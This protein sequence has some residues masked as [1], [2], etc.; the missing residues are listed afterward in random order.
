MGFDRFQQCFDGPLLSLGPLIVCRKFS[1]RGVLS[2]TLTVSRFDNTLG[3]VVRFEILGRRFEV[4]D[5]AGLN[6]WFGRV[7]LMLVR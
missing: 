1:T 4:R 3:T 6:L 7:F 5:F 2:N